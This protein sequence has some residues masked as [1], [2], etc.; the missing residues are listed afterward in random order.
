MSN[1]TRYRGMKGTFAGMEKGLRIKFSR[2]VN[3]IEAGIRDLAKLAPKPPSGEAS[4]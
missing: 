2:M 1:Y 3:Q 4:K